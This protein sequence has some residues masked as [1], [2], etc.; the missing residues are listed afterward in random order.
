[1]T[2]NTSRHTWRNGVTTLFMSTILILSG[3][4]TG[5]GFHLRGDFQLPERVESIAVS[6]PERSEVNETLIQALMQ[7]GIEVVEP[8]AGI[9]GIILQQDSMDRRILSLLPSGQV[10]EYEL[11]Y[12]LPVTF[13]TANGVTSEQT[14][15]LTRDY[16]DNPNF[17]LA[18]MRELELVVDEMRQEAVARTLILLNQYVRRE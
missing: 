11:I 16:Q 7:R 8:E 1:M 10:A 12:T 4:L 3:A 17:A 15:Q 2:L 9:P 14:I 6:S 18:K 5:C 13:V